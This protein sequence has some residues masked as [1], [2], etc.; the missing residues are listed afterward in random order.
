[1]TCLI[2]PRTSRLG[3][4]YLERLKLVYAGLVDKMKSSAEI[5]SPVDLI[6]Q[7]GLVGNAKPASAYRDC[8]MT[9][10]IFGVASLAGTPLAELPQ[11]FARG[12]SGGCGGGCGGG[13]GGGGGCG[14][15]GCGGGC[16]GCGGG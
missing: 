3:R 7:P 12:T 4:A 9:L 11:L 10:G 2:T 13:G 1:M 6:G 8:L 15:G 5:G 16:G 14:G